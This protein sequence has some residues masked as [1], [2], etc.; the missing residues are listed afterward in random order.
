MNAAAVRSNKF[1][2]NSCFA[3]S[4]N[5]LNAHCIRPSMVLKANEIFIGLAQGGAVKYASDPNCVK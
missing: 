4:A 2:E 3:A 5:N 1:S